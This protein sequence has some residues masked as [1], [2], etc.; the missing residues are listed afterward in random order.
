MD[1]DNLSNA[2]N[3]LELAITSGVLDTSKNKIQ[4]IINKLQKINKSTKH[5]NFVTDTDSN[6]TDGFD[7]TEYSQTEYS[8]TV[9]GYESDIENTSDINSVT[10][11]DNYSQTTCSELISITN[12]QAPSD[13]FKTLIESEMHIDSHTFKNKNLAFEK[14]IN[15]NDADSDEIIVLKKK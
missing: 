4:K 5:N 8:D 15:E 1:S 14:P 11:S 3:T 6:L 9:S 7:Q 2:L 10:S 12:N 13:M